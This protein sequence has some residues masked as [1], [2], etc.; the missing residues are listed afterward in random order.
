MRLVHSALD[1]MMAIVASAIVI[2]VGGIHGWVM[3]SCLALIYCVAWMMVVEAKA[4][5]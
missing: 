4:I 5:P 2:G 3:S 1:V